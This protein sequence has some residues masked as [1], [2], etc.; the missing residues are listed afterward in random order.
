[1]LMITQCQLIYNKQSQYQQKQ[2]CA[3][4]T[5]G[6]STNR[7][8]ICYS[9]KTNTPQHCIIACEHYKLYT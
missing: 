5:M 7:D 8:T 3:W 2:V 9:F 4:I 6:I 1:M